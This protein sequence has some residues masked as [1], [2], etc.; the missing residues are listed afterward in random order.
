MP[1]P[2]VIQ[3]IQDFSDKYLSGNLDNLAD[4]QLTRLKNDKRFGC[5]GRS[6]DS[7]DT[8]IMRCIYVALFSDVWPDLS[9]QSLKSGDFRG[10]TLNTYNTL[11]GRPDELSVHPGLDRFDTSNEL[12]MKNASF[13]VHFSQI[14][15]M[16]VLPNLRVNGKSINTYRGCHAQWR[17]YFDRFLLAL[18]DILADS[19]NVDSGLRGLVAANDI[20]FANYKGIDGFKLLVDS[21]LLNDYV[22]ADYNPIVSSKGYYFW[23]RGLSSSD[24]VAE[25]HRYIDFSNMVIEHRTAKMIERLKVLCVI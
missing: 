19:D 18:R 23:K 4:F 2:H 6:F 10:D 24:Y 14:G 11:F 3:T 21:L 7:D 8:E 5:P 9:L 15:N 20:Y 22:D 13:R 25:A 17:D 16:T 1:T 12:R